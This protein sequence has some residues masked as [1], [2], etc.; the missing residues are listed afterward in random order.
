M[1][2]VISVDVSSSTFVRV[3]YLAVAESRALT[4][5]CFRKR[6]LPKRSASSGM[7]QATA[8]G[9][10]AQKAEIVEINLVWPLYKHVQRGVV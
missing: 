2:D 4:Q 3:A 9:Q 1:P 6:V 10:P 7:L 8:L 5:H